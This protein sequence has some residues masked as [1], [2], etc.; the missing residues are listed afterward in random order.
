VTG[1]LR[2]CSAGLLRAERAVRVVVL[3]FDAPA[4]HDHLR[5][6]VAAY[7]YPREV[8]FVPSLPITATG[9]IMRGVLRRQ[10]S[11]ETA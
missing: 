4:L 3:A 8:H 10:F 9:K 6:R 1:G 5:Q 11:Q 7:A 2:H